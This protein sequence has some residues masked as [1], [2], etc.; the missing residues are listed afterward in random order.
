[1]GGDTSTC[2]N[3]ARPIALDQWGD[4][5]H[6]ANGAAACTNG[7]SSTPVDAPSP[8]LW[9]E[10]AAPAPER[11][12]L[13]RWWTRA[14]AVPRWATVLAALLFLVV[15]VA[16]GRTTAEDDPPPPTRTVMRTVAVPGTRTVT[17]A[18]TPAAC[19]D[20]IDATRD[21]ADAARVALR[22]GSVTDEVVDEV[23]AELER[24]LA[25]VN[26]SASNCD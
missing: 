26:R 14:A 10:P 16:V 8:Q 5:Y 21:V 13:R 7:S 2:A 12:A 3:C 19:A 4:W 9:V 18:T 23:R 24:A 15:G 22:A 25:R 20:A 11:G 17:V 1:M 6:V